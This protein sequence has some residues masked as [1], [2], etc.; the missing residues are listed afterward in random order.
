MYASEMSWRYHEDANFQIQSHIS[1]S[2]IWFGSLPSAPRMS[3]QND[4]T[5]I[6][7]VPGSLAWVYKFETSLGWTECVSAVELKPNTHTHTYT[8]ISV[9]I[10]IIYR[11]IY[12]THTHTLIVSDINTVFLPLL[13]WMIWIRCLY[14]DLSWDSPTFDQHISRM[15]TKRRSSTSLPT[16]ERPECLFDR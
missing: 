9:C 2:L 1:N 15:K 11:Y 5:T 10:Y 7:K 4:L 6:C 14:L 8:H 12:N 16:L 3:Q 13:F